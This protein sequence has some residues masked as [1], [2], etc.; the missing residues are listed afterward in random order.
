[1]DKVNDES[2]PKQQYYNQSL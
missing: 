2:T 1:M